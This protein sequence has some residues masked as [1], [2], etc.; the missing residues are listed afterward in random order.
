MSSMLIFVCAQYLH[1]PV[2]QWRPNPVY[3]LHQ[4]ATMLLMRQRISNLHLRV[5]LW[6]HL[7]QLL[8]HAQP[9]NKSS[10]PAK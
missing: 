7:I 1:F 9:P 2:P 6:E 8:L 5:L 4:I 10:K 3:K